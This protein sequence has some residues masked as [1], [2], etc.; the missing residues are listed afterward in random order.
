MTND[1]N[2]AIRVLEK[3]CSSS[4]EDMVKT[5][6]RLMLAL[7]HNQTYG[8]HIDVVLHA[9]RLAEVNAV[10]QRLAL[11]TLKL[12]EKLAVPGDR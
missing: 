3:N 11:G 6:Q 9:L 4:F 2:D 1:I 7:P 10:K 5:A 12:R 8:E